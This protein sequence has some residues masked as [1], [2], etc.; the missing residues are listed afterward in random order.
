MDRFRKPEWRQDKIGN[1]FNRIIDDPRVS[2]I[3]NPKHLNF[4]LSEKDVNDVNILWGVAPTGPIHIGYLIPLNKL[5]DF[6]SLGFKL[7][8]IIADLHAYLDDKKSSLD[9]LEVRTE[10]YRQ[11]FGA[12][13]LKDI[14]YIYGIKDIHL[15]REYLE[16]LFILS[17]ESKIDEIWKSFLTTLRI[18]D[19]PTVSAFIYTLMQ[20]L[21]IRY[22]NV[23]LVLVGNDELPIYDYGM[24]LLKQ[25]YN[26]DFTVLSTSL[27]HDITG[28]EKMSC[29]KTDRSI[30]IHD[31]P[32]IIRSK[33]E[34]SIC[35]PKNTSNNMC[36]DIVK[37]IL[38]PNVGYVNVGSQTI[39]N[40]QS[41]LKG[42]ENAE[43]S[44]QELKKSVF[45]SL[46]EI[47]KP[48]RS[49]FAD[50]LELIERAQG[51]SYDSYDV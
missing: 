3:R 8:L 50:K 46:I 13:G 14:K 49:Y 30:L 4:T 1:L 10:Y 6:K 19:F 33:I 43:I 17:T 21:D 24:N 34:A 16:E 31:P 39:K 40:L 7:K 37:F 48:V 26:Y 45:S 25:A 9:T 27:L 20:I 44:P 36:V 22:L 29:S 12:L 35:Q 5:L 32:H 41:F 38:I 15:N 11:C 42:Y 23:D 51:I 2:Q 18:K 47:L 28:Y